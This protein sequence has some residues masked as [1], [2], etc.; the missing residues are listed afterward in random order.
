MKKAAIILMLV[1]II[2]KVFGLIRDIILSYFYGTSTISDAYLVSMTIS[3]VVFGFIASG[4]STGYIPMYRKI[5]ERDGLKESYKY[6]N[7]LLNMLLLLSTFIVLFGILYTEQLVRIF[8]SG[9]EGHALVLTVK[10]TRISLI[11]IY[12]TALINLFT[13]FLQ[14]HG[15]YT[16]PALIG[17]PLNFITILAIYI[18]SNNNPMVLAVGALVAIVSQW[19][20]LLPSI[21]RTGYRYRF[22]LDFKDKNIKNMAIIAL[23]VIIGV[24]IDQINVLVDRTIAS[25]IAVGG[26]SAL[27]YANRLNGFVQGIFVV[28]ISTVMYPLISKMAAEKNM[29]GLKS[30]VSEAVGGINLLVMPATIGA[31]VFAEPIVTLLFGRGEFD[32]KAISMTSQA[33]FFFSVGMIGFGIREVLS[34]VF[35]SMQDTKT[36]MINAVMA[37]VINIILNIILSKFLGIGGLA[38]ATSISAL[39]CTFLLMVSLRKKI[40]S[41]G[42]R[43]ISISFIKILIAS[44]MM[45]LLAKLIYN[46]MLHNINV[47]L[48]LIF[49]ILLGAIIY[50]ILIYLMKVNEVIVILDILKKKMNKS[51][52]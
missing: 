1:S 49:S 23:P 27:N 15:K 46:F 47:N 38:L 36:P 20:L 50:L 48:S 8:A 24:S 43:N 44:L 16:I 30:T 17:F 18:S 51:H 28:S 33:L 42:M 37:L 4:I 10:F 7:N 32:D 14:I 26:I 41:F 11:G 2:S 5:E 19:I 13:G 12:F 40:G 45:G 25:Q 9:F 3:T 52:S 29:N 21:H 6:T 35:Y 34:K 22:I 39:F 31:M